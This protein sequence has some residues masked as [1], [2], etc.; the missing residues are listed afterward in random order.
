MDAQSDCCG[1]SLNFAEPQKEPVRSA[2]SAL[3]QSKLLLTKPLLGDP[4]VS[5]LLEPPREPLQGD[6]LASDLPEPP[7]EGD[8]SV[9]DL[10]EPPE[11]PLPSDCCGTGCSPCVFDIYRED[12]ERWE[13]LSRLTPG[14]RAARLRNPSRERRKFC[15]FLFPCE[16][17]TCEVIAVK[18]V[19]GDSYI[20]T[21]QLP[22]ECILGAG[23]GQHAVLR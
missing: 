15:S 10:P 16:Y 22:E 13:E 4:L 8:P 2:L 11:E 7:K 23:L 3:P 20:F 19:S 17:R 6:L 5:G 12:L 1:A 18:Q 9:S 14:E 21:F